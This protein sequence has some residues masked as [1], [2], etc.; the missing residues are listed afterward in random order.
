MVEELHFSLPITFAWYDADRLPMFERRGLAEPVS[1]CQ[2][3]IPNL[4]QITNLDSRVPSDQPIL[5]EDI[6]ICLCA[7]QSQIWHQSRSS[8]DQSE[9]DMSVVLQRNT[10]RRQLDTIYHRLVL[11]STQK[12][13]KNTLGEEEH[14]PL[15]F[16]FGIEDHGRPGWESL[17]LI[18]LKGLIF[19][20]L[21]LYHLLSLQLCLNTRT[22]IELAKD[23]KTA[24]PYIIFGEKYEEARKQRESMT[25]TWV[26]TPS[27]RRALWHATEILLSHDFTSQDLDTHFETPDPIAYIALSASAMV[28]WAFCLFGLNSCDECSSAQTRFPPSGGPVIEL[29]KLGGVMCRYSS[30][31]K[32][33]IAWIEMGVDCRVLLDGIQLCRCSVDSLLSRFRKYLPDGWKNVNGVAPEILQTRPRA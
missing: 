4:M 28:I 11:Y 24:N 1:R 9:Q 19:D 18:R 29:A 22:L 7:I 31:E 17:V 10:V 33:K 23:T 12:V 6:Q 15:K 26:K 25:R 2:T 32:D 5:I 30:D 14:I 3:T 13:D 27:A 20:A 21:M 8:M 16:Y